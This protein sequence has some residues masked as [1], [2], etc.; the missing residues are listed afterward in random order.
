MGQ[1]CKLDVGCQ[2]GKISVRGEIPSFP[3]NKT[4][5]YIFKKNCMADYQSQS[6]QFVC[7]MYDSFGS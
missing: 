3:L 4:N 7:N 1:E 5:S 2:V 6:V